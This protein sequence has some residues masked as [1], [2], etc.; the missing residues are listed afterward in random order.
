MNLWGTVMNHSGT[1]SL[2][3]LALG[4]FLAVTG[5]GVWSSAALADEGRA[6]V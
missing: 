4:F 6:P 5:V 3:G 1:R 2:V